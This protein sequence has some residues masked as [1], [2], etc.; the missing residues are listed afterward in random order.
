MLIQ[1]GS[2]F[3]IMSVRHSPDS[4]SHA[5]IVLNSSP[6]MTYYTEGV[7]PTIVTA[8]VGSKTFNNPPQ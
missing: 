6:V 5:L 1:I 4:I 7:K 3:N 2:S 8:A